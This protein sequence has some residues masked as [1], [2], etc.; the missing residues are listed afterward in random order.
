MGATQGG[1]G[2]APIYARL[3]EFHVSFVL[4]DFRISGRVSVSKMDGKVARIMKG[5]CSTSRERT[6][7]RVLLV[8][9][10][11]SCRVCFVKR[12]IRSL[13]GPCE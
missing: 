5:G 4:P 8:V 2:H 7:T 12:G 13:A 10:S 1:N 3:L 6:E 9:S 11:V